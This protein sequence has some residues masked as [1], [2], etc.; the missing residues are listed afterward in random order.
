MSIALITTRTKKWN[1]VYF[2]VMDETKY[3]VDMY[4]DYSCQQRDKFMYEKMFFPNL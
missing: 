2:C 3:I 4:S 1:G